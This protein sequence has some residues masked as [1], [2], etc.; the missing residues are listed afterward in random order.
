MKKLLL[1]ASIMGVIYAQSTHAHYAKKREATSHSG[2]TAHKAQNA[3]K[4]TTI[5]INE[6]VLDI[7]CIGA[8]PACLEPKRLRVV[9]SDLD[10]EEDLAHKQR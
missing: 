1:I 9:G 6:P 7:A 2:Q 8:G 4:S 3:T 10:D 5:N